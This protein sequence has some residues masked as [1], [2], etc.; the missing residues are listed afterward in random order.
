MPTRLQYQTTECGVAALSMILAYYGCFTSMQAIRDVSGVSRDCMNA[1]DMVRSARHFGLTCKVYRRE[2]EAL[3]AMSFPFVAHLKFIHFVVVEGITADH[4]LVNDPAEGR[5][6]I[7]KEQFHEM[8]TGIVITFQPSETFVPHGQAFSPTRALWQRLSRTTKAGLVLA[9]A[10]SFLLVLPVVSMALVMGGLVEPVTNPVSS[11]LVPALQPGVLYLLVSAPLLYAAIGFFQ[12]L[13]LAGTQN[14]MAA[15]L[16]GELLKAIYN[17]PFSYFSYRLPSELQRTLYNTGRIS[18]LLCQDLVP[19][20]LSVPTV[21]IYLAG[22]FYVSPII[23]SLLALLM[24]LYGCV[25]ALMYR[26]RDRADGVD[27][28]RAPE[29]YQHLISGVEMIE[30]SKIAG[31]DHDYVCNEMAVHAVNSSKEQQGLLSRACGSVAGKLVA[32]AA[33][34]TTAVG[35]AGWLLVGQL[36][37]GELI[38]ALVL[39]G[40]MTMAVQG[41]PKAQGAYRLW[42]NLMAR[43]IDVPELSGEEAAP[44]QETLLA[45]AVAGPCLQMQSVVFGHTR[46]RPAL[47]EGLDFVLWPGEQVGIT[48]PS[49]GGKS[50]FGG[51]AAGLHKP[52]SGTVQ[53]SALE[54]KEK[55]FATAPSSPVVWI[56]K[57]PFL[58]EGTV[59]E[60][61]ELWHAGYSDNTLWAA[62]KDAC[63]DDVLAARPAGLDS[64]VDVRGRN[65]SGGQRQRL[66]LA[67]ALLRNPA[68]LI[69]DEALDALDPALETRLRSALR[70]RNCGVIVISHR[71]STLAACDRTLHFVERK[72]VDAGVEDFADATATGHAQ[73]L[74]GDQVPQ[75]QVRDTMAFRTPEP[76]ALTAVLKSLSKRMGCH[77]F[78]ADR[79]GAEAD[80]GPI[81]AQAWRAGLYAQHFR[82]IR[83]VWWKRCHW[84]LLGFLRGTG[85]PVVVEPTSRGYMVQSTAGGPPVAASARTLQAD[86]YCL[87]SPH[88]LDDKRAQALFGRGIAAVKTD[89]L[90]ALI[91][92]FT[93]AALT[94]IIPLVAGFFMAGNQLSLLTENWDRLVIS[95]VGLLLIFGL[96]ETAKE[97]ALIRLSACL[98]T[99]V[100]AELFQRLIRLRP[101]FVRTSAPRELTRALASVPRCLKIFQ[102]DI[103]CQGLALPRC[104]AGLSLL[105]WIDGRLAAIAGVLLVPFFIVPPAIGIATIALDHE[106]N[107]RRVAGRRFLMDILR[108]FARLR[109]FGAEFLAA[110]HW[111]NRYGWELES[112]RKLNLVRSLLKLFT[113]SYSWFALSLLTVIVVASMAP[114]SVDLWQIV[115][116]YIALWMTLESA[117]DLGEAM[118]AAARLRAIRPDLERLLAAPLET[119]GQI[120]PR[121][122]ALTA[123]GVG[124]QYPGTQQWALKG[125]SLELA[126]GEV[127]SIVGPSGG[128]KSTLLRLLL[129]FEQAKQGTVLAGGVAL[130]E[131]DLIDWRRD[132]GVVQQDDRCEMASTIRSQVT[133]KAD[134]EVRDAW[135]ALELADLADDV[136]AMPM[137]IQTIVERDVFS[138]GQ[139]Q[140][141][142]IAAQL[143]RRPSLLILDEATNAITEHQ[144]ARILQNIRALGMSC[145]LVSH[146]ESTVMAADRVYMLDGGKMVWSGPPKEFMAQQELVEKIRQERRVDG[147]PI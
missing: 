27:V 145:I 14:R 16:A 47:V 26:V 94:L 4:V 23:G 41:W 90:R 103:L 101:S 105:A 123:K 31:K 19:L 64:P 11:A 75:Q 106:H 9:A 50:T 144:Q 55:R 89:F 104:L 62:L 6:R 76:A 95:G 42:Y 39:G 7:S 84:P 113:T 65:F 132:I 74:I 12:N 33:L 109:S 125:A 18:R 46:A 139:E 44:P 71:T 54:T 80:A 69:L 108:G 3:P 131:L 119:K 53:T 67:R 118:A 73:P 30:A 141:L 137:G 28:L 34:I 140:R 143:L 25:L 79:H 40:G 112:E 85:E 110:D 136:R 58:F 102:D 32:V 126:P 81:I 138:T 128:G 49:G 8:F 121:G 1:A 72:L 68:V 70:R 91:L 86:A 98:G 111:Q 142:L 20:L 146:R 66:E 57:S 114:Q 43:H 129:G 22:L 13:V 97:I 61:L 127:I 24:A 87:Y 117:A 29:D 124:F 107:H 59:R 36:Q 51:L 10:S 82:F 5:S 45:D 120:L 21:L 60:N 133:G 88:A 35:G 83:D 134:K 115:A 122:A 78:P 48:G 52:W 56:D 96:L 147:E 100:R 38:S 77:R 93:L 37:T 130:D 2:P 63:L 15:E 116:G 92:S 17:Q 135:Q 99:S